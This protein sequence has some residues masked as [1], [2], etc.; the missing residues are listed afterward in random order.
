MVELVSPDDG[1]CSV[2]LEVYF[3]GLMEQLSITYSFVSS[4]L[5]IEVLV[6]HMRVGLAHVAAECL[7]FRV[8]A[9]ADGT[10]VFVKSFLF[11]YF[12]FHYGLSLCLL[13]RLGRFVRFLNFFTLII[14]FF[15][16]GTFS[17]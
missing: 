13:S 6:A 14:L 8:L 3:L 9:V 5:L 15:L 1:A 7:S 2:L 11:A 4:L 16:G 12:L 10:N 17:V